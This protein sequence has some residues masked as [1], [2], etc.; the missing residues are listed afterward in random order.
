MPFVTPEYE[1]FRYSAILAAKQV[2]SEA[3]QILMKLPTLEQIDSILIDNKMLIPNRQMVIDELGPLIEFIDFRRIK[4]QILVDIIEPLKIVP[5]EIIS[6]VYKH[7]IMTNNL[8]ISDIRGIPIYTKL[9]KSG[10]IWD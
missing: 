4:D 5:S 2:S 8:L 10:L 7:T 9:N 1:V 6:N 3:Y